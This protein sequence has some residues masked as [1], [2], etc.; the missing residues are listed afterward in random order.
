[1]LQQHL[2]RQLVRLIAIVAKVGP[3]PVTQLAPAAR[4]RHLADG[5]EYGPVEFEHLLPQ[6]KLWEE[7]S[8]H[9]KQNAK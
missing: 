3:R 6:H 1:M 9:G 8:K 7:N 4:V 5:A 2:D